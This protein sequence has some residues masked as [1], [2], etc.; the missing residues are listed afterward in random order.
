MNVRIVRR[1]QGF[2][3]RDEHARGPARKLQPRTCRPI[4]IADGQAQH[5]FLVRP[6]PDGRIGLNGRHRTRGTLSQTH[7]ECEIAIVAPHAHFSRRAWNPGQD[8]A[9]EFFVAGDGTPVE[10]GD[11]PGDRDQRLLRGVERVVAVG[12]H[13]PAHRVHVVGVPVEERLERGAIAAR[14]PRGE[15]VAVLIQTGPR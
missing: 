5:R 6:R 10:A 3:A 9:Q 1:T 8:P 12:E 4:E 11:A 13:A 15:R 7:G 2:D 14:R